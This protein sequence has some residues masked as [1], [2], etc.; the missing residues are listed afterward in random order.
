MPYDWKSNDEDQFN[1]AYQQMSAA[2]EILGW[3][4]G[5]NT[6]VYELTAKYDR[7]GLLRNVGAHV[8]ITDNA[9]RGA[10]SAAMAS[11]DIHTAAKSSKNPSETGIGLARK[12]YIACCHYHITFDTG[13]SLYA[14]DNPRWYSN[15]NNFVN[16]PNDHAGDW[17]AVYNEALKV[18][19][20]IGD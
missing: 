6:L 8:T 3:N 14:A 7:I 18:M 13:D 5:D 17:N 9:F 16:W 1:D 10:L 12:H 4:L 19:T 15:G 11:A 2:M 20:A